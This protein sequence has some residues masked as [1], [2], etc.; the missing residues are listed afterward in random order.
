[1]AVKGLQPGSY[2]YR[3]DCGRRGAKIVGGGKPMD[4]YLPD[5]GNLELNPFV[6]IILLI[7]AFLFG[8]A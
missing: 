8:L 6:I 4:K 1:V 7:F 3:F 2:G 5:L